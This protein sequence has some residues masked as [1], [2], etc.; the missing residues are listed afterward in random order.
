MGKPKKKWASKYLSDELKN[1]E[2]SITSSSNIESN[3]SDSNLSDEYHFEKQN[4]YILPETSLQISDNPE[5]VTSIT[6]DRPFPVR[7]VPTY[8]CGR[9]LSTGIAEFD[10]LRPVPTFNNGRH[11]VERRVDPKLAEWPNFYSPFHPPVNHNVTEYKTKECEARQ[12]QQLSPWEPTNIPYNFDAIHYVTNHLSNIEITRIQAIENNSN[13]DSN[14]CNSNSFPSGDSTSNELI[15]STKNQKNNYVQD[16]T[17]VNA[18]INSIS[19]KSKSITKEKKPR[20][21]RG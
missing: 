5:I 4:V 18:T 17:P 7:P 2:S 12:R 15:Q 11:L 19:P 20:I 14:S 13:E 6:P 21:R 16:V 10:P 9:D 8:N 3:T 1:S